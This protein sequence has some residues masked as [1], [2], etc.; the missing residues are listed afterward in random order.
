MPRV[1]LEPMTPVSERIKT[2]QL[3]ATFRSNQEQWE[4]NK[5][6]VSRTIRLVLHKLVIERREANPAH[7]H[8]AM[9][10]HARVEFW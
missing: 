10:K 7:N 9:K 5:S 3:P 6:P 1:G 8:F 2:V 4:Q